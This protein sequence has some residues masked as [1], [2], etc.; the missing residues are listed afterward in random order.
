MLALQMAMQ[1]AVIPAGVRVIRNGAPMV[2]LIVMALLATTNG[3]LDRVSPILCKQH[4]DFLQRGMAPVRA[5]LRTVN[6]AQM[7][8]RDSGP[9]IALVLQQPGVVV[10]AANIPILIIFISGICIAA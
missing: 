9:A 10:H 7:A 3:R 1:W 2:R 8:E 5:D 4:L 6:A